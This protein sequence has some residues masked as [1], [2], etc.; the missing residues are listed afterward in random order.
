M[1][2][3]LLVGKGG[4]LGFELMRTCPEDFGLIALTEKELDVT[5]KDAVVDMVKSISPEIIINC[6]AYTAVDKAESETEKAFAVNATGSAN[7]ARA[8]DET[9][10]LLIHVSTDFVFDGGAGVPYVPEAETNPLSVYGK[11]KLAG[12]REIQSIGCESIIVR[13]S[14]LYRSFGN[15][16]VKTMLKLMAER[17]TLGVVADQ[18]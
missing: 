16:F 1:N 15:N 5:C 14:W 6:A 9:D 7:L 2:E 18:I 3:V 12:E 10:A 13:T 11:S 4:Q 17:E 8:A